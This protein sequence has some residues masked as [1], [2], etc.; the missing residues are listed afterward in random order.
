MYIHTYLYLLLIPALSCTV[1]PTEYCYAGKGTWSSKSSCRVN[2][3]ERYLNPVP[4]QSTR[5]ARPSDRP[6][7]MSLQRE[8]V[9]LYFWDW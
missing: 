3:V 7:S 8:K 2:R 1:L 5:V 6:I 4:C 9:H